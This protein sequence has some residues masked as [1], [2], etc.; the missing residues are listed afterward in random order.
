MSAYDK[1]A[2]LIEIMLSA[3]A[4]EANKAQLSVECESIITRGMLEAFKRG[5]DY[6]HERPTNP[7][8]PPKS[9]TPSGPMPAVRPKTPGPM[10]AV[11]PPKN[12]PYP[13]KKY[14]DDD[15]ER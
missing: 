9:K 12:S 2:D 3:V 10:P 11:R 6:A 8:P 4:Q 14:R 13:P 15:E 7:P 5:G 1:V